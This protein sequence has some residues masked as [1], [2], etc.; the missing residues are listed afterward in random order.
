MERKTGTPATGAR[1]RRGKRS[2][3]YIAIVAVVVIGLIWQEQVALLY[4]LAT[5]S[6]S[7]LLVVVAFSD[8][9]HARRAAPAAPGDDSAAAGDAMNVAAAPPRAAVRR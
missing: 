4:V 7:A 6:V 8:L 1:K 5:L 9:G 3:L 2:L